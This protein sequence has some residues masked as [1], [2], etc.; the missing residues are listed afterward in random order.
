MLIRPWLNR[1]SLR[2]LFGHP[3][4]KPR[5]RR[6]KVVRASAAEILESRQ[7]LTAAALSGIETTPLAYTE[8]NTTAVTSSLVITAGTSPT[9]ASATVTISANYQSGEDFLTFANTANITGSFDSA[10]GVLTL[11]GTD[12]VANY[13]A[14]LQSVMYHTNQNPNSDPRTVSFVVNDGTTASNTVTRTIDVTPVNNPPLLSSIETAPLDFTPG[15]AATPITSTLLV[16]DPDNDNLTGATVT[17]TGNYQNGEDVLAFTNTSKITGTFNATTGTLT[18]TGTDTVADYRDALRSVTYKDTSANPNDSV[19]TISIVANDGSSSTPTV[20][21]S[22]T[23]T[24]NID[25]SPVLS[26]IETT[27]LSYS[28]NNDSTSNRPATPITGTLVLSDTAGNTISGATVQI[29]GAYQQGQDVLAFTNAS[30]ITGTFDATTGKLTL[31]GTATVA[32]YQ[33]ALRSVTYQNT[34]AS[35]T[36]QTRTVTFTVTDSSTAASN[37]VTRNINVQSSTVV[38]GIETTPLAYTEGNPA[39]PVTSALTLSDN[40]GTTVSGAIVKISSGLQTG[41]ILAFTNTSKITGSYNATTGTL[42]LTGSD[43]LADY[44]AALRSVTFQNTTNTSNATRTVSFQVGTTL[45]T[46]A[47]TRDIDVTPVFNAPV[48]SGAD[49]H[50][51]RQ[52]HRHGAAAIEPDLQL[53]VAASTTLTGATVT[54]GNFHAADVLAFTKVGNITGT[55]NSV[56]GVLTLTGSDTVANYQQALRSVTFDSTASH[57][58]GLRDISFEVSNG[59]TNSAIVDRKVRALR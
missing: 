15:Q 34:S 52:R 46:A 39:T 44:Q 59:T 55:F 17:I 35:I 19:R 6:T 38:S 58:H 49:H 28:V 1:L 53:S 54:I 8:G 51:L 57:P 13:Q 18:L 30:G 24:R 48:I 41:D 32:Q 9:L 47:V 12:T 23:V 7:L 3:A 29:T 50:R 2:S 20:P 45:L 25:I 14:A 16:A 37:S 11:T 22:N 36:G 42:T 27:P 56:T 26:Q 40:Q 31:T 5:T 43:T 33:A 4:V 10:T 21:D